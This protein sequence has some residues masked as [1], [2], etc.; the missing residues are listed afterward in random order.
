M[1]GAYFPPPR[2]SFRPGDSFISVHLV[3]VYQGR[4]VVFD[5]EEPPA[6]GRW[7][8]W[9]VAWFRANPYEVASALVEE[10][11]GSFPDD[12]RFVD[13]LSFETE[14]GGWE[15]ALVFRAELSERPAGG[16]ARR[17]VLL[18]R[19]ALTAAG[20]FEAVELSR[21][22]GPFPEERPSAPTLLF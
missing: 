4:L 22:V 15:L 11:C 5:I 7:I 14:G 10:W 12:L 1:E 19:G 3:P 18:E 8:P 9:T 6:R 13:A 2:T 16:G 20:R 17:P 21:W